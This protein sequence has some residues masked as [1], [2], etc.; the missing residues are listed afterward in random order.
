MPPIAAILS[1][2]DGTLVDSTTAVLRVWHGWMADRGIVPPDHHPHGIPA[3]E[4][5]AM[6]APHLDPVAEADEL[7]RREIADLDGV[8]ALPGARELLDPAAAGGRPPVA[9][10][11]SCTVPLAAARLGACGLPAPPLLVTSERTARVKPHPDPYLMAARELGVDP[12]ACVVLEDAPAGI[13]AGR[14][15]GMR[16]VA[17]RGTHEDDGPLAAADAIVDD[18]AAF[19]AGLSTPA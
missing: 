18:V 17:V 6:L 10:V 15:A 12:A 11:T 13:A 3:R 5:V 9:I 14:A 7:E 1:D 8:V 19:L 2:L 4:V 16:V